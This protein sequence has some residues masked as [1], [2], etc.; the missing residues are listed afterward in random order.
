MGDASFKWTYIKA[1]QRS[2]EILGVELAKPAGVRVA[3]DMTLHADMLV[4]GFGAPKGTLVFEKTDQ[5]PRYFE[6]LW[7]QGFTPSSFSPYA[8]GAECSLLGMVEVLS[9]WGWEGEGPEPRWL[10]TL[11]AAGWTKPDDFYSALLPR[12]QAPNW[13]GHNLDALWDGMTSGDING[14]NPP[15]AVRLF[16]TSEFSAEMVSYME[17]VVKVFE[18]AQDE[19]VPVV[20]WVWP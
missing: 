8:D 11:D 3:R 14:L 9:D 6:E 2:A 1:W 15:F 4:R 5:Y 13:H 10:I 17:R 19:N 16:N 12:L 20:I 7:E 18:A